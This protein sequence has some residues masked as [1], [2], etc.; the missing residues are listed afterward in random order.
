MKIILGEQQLQLTI[1][2]LAHQ[3]AENHLQLQNTVIIG[4]QP[5]GVFFSDKLVHELKLLV[6]P[7]KVEYGKLDIT[8][9][10]D[11][12][13]KSLHVANKTDILFSIENKNV[14]LVD[15]VLFTGRTIRAAF[16]AI[17]DFGRPQKVALCVLIDRRFS[18]EF[19]IQPTY[20]GRAIDTFISEKV[21]VYWKDK[22]GREE[23]ELQ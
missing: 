3:I 18:R 16:D 13:R 6:A 15:D 22:D 7:N 14:I 4:L 2:R 11:D 17:L 12:V 21:K 19:P 23:V 9:Y 1:K 5:R 20:T 10:R 8:F